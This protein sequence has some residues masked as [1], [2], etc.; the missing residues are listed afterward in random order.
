MPIKVHKMSQTSKAHISQTMG[1]HACAEG[2]HVE[3]KHRPGLH[4]LSP[5]TLS[6]QEGTRHRHHLCEPPPCPA[7]VPSHRHHLS[8]MPC[9]PT[10]ATCAAL[11]HLAHRLGCVLFTSRS[12]AIT[13][14]FPRAETMFYLDWILQYVIQLKSRGFLKRRHCNS[15][16][17]T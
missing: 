2:E 11:M 16:G 15:L 8:E 4:C 14:S 12:T 10:D 5:S 1:I 3:Q 17:K 6:C 13:M 9:G 7:P